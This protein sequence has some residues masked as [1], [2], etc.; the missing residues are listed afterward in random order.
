MNLFDRVLR[1]ATA[2]VMRRGFTSAPRPRS[3]DRSAVVS[4]DEARHIVDRAWR[5]Y[6][7]EV[8]ALP[9]EPTR[10]SRLLVRLACASLMAQRNLEAAG[11]APADARRLVAEV[12]WTCYRPLVRLSTQLARWRIPAAGPRL[13]A[14]V[15]RQLK[16]PFDE[17]G[18]R[19]QP[20]D[21][22]SYDVLRCPIADYLCARDA[23]ELCVAAFCDQDHLV[24]AVWGARLHRRTTIAEGADR[25]DFRYELAS[26]EKVT[27][28]WR[29]DRST[30]RRTARRTRYQAG[31]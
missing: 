10:G 24:A 12:N 30:I 18:W 21:D 1:I 7:V 15:R 8:E 26:P 16:S 9:H 13:V 11:V 20:F 19:H 23:S 22:L 3:T 5:D 29:P 25:C 17:P 4:R 28:Q 6:S 27:M 14:Q 31:S 2:P